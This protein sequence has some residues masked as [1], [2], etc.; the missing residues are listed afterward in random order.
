MKTTQRATTFAAALLAPAF[1]MAHTGADA[2]AHHNFLDALLYA[3]SDLSLPAMVVALGIWG[4]IF[5]ASRSA[6]RRKQE[7]AQ[8]A[9]KEA[10]R[11]NDL[12]DKP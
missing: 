4:A 2:G 6:K 3:L 5:A 1:A 12:R 11:R 10:M 7:A 9:T 8:E